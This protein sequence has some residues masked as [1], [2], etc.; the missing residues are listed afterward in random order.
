M[1]LCNHTLALAPFNSNDMLNPVYSFRFVLRVRVTPVAGVFK[2]LV[3]LQRKR[4]SSQFK[5]VSLSPSLCHFLYSILSLSLPP[6]AALSSI[7]AALLTHLL[8]FLLPSTFHKSI[9][10]AYKP[11]FQLALCCLSLNRFEYSYRLFLLY[12]NPPDK[13]D[14]VPPQLQTLS[15][16]I[17]SSISGLR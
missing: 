9:P 5:T 8:L 6:T 3:Q 15:P 10:P 16:V 1:S 11:A 2:D 17:K 12:S 4:R 14:L 7:K 13:P